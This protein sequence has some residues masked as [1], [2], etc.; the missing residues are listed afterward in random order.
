MFAFAGIV[1][2]HK[3]RDYLVRRFLGHLRS[4][5]RKRGE[6]PDASKGPLSDINTML[7]EIQDGPDEGMI[8]I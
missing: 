1:A 3:G 6:W 4:A 2:L 7:N 5:Q 8:G